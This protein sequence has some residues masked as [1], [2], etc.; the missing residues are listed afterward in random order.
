MYKD[1]LVLSPNKLNDANRDKVI[2]RMTRTNDLV[3]LGTQLE[4][5]GL[6]WQRW[7]KKNRI[8]FALDSWSQ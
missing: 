3:Q 5:L 4:Q 8:I 2:E 6:M 1:K 7:T